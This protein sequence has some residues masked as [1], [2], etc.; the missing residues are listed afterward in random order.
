MFIYK[1]M[2]IKIS[3]LQFIIFLKKHQVYQLYCICDL[4]PYEFKNTHGTMPQIVL[5]YV[6]HA[7]LI[8]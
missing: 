3:E 8:R 7:M 1:W 2:K 6:G 5:Q 4:A